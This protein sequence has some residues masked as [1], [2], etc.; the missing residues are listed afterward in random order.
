MW[1]YIAIYENQTST[2]TKYKLIMLALADEVLCQFMT[3][4]FSSNNICGN[5]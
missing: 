2:P 3:N 5:K 1:A 4:A